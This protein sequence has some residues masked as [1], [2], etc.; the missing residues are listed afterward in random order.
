[1]TALRDRL[2]YANVMATIAVFLAL[3]GGAYAAVKLTKNSVKTK[4]ITDGAVTQ[5]KISS[6]AQ[7]AL[8]GNTGPPGPP[9][10]PGSPA[11]A[12]TR[13]I[14]G[15]SEDFN[16]EPPGG[17]PVTLFLSN[18]VVQ[19]LGP[20]QLAIAVEAEGIDNSGGMGTM[21]CFGRITFSGGNGVHELQFPEVVLP[22]GPVPDEVQVTE[23]HVYAGPATTATIESQCTMEGPVT[24]NGSLTPHVGVTGL[25]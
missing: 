4:H 18:V 15:A 2:T 19:D 21:E 24:M 7:Q 14:S 23:L 5:A 3:G 6:A 13:L 17:S 16:I 10:T 20:A 25:G 22:D 11:N 9:G 12:N 8:R 1:M